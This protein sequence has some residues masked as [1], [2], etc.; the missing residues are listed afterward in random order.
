MVVGI[1]AA[2]ARGRNALLCTN[3]RLGVRDRQL[4]LQEQ[5]ILNKG[6]RQA[7]LNMPLDVAVEQED[8]ISNKPD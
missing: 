2:V 4:A 5:R 7:G 3:L 6:R 1:T 8:S